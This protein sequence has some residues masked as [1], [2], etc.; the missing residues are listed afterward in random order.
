M[1]FRKDVTYSGDLTKEVE[2][3]K[4]EEANHSNKKVWKYWLA[5]AV[6]GAAI[7]TV[8]MIFI[9]NSSF[10]VSVYD[11]EIRLSGANGFSLPLVGTEC[12]I[13]NTPLGPIDGYSGEGVL[14]G[15]HTLSDGSSGRFAL[16]TGK[17][18]IVKLTY[19]GKM[20]YVNFNTQEETQKLYTT[21]IESAKKEAS[22]ESEK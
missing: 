16:H 1:W 7:V 6:F 20:Y 21:I 13:L 2:I 4:F 11:G 12:S 3:P 10:S 18:P 15:T 17:A 22:K 19:G 5:A 14:T 9:G 8:I